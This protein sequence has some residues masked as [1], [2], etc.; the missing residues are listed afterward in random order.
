MK[1]RK[2]KNKRKKK[3]HWVVRL[4]EKGIGQTKYVTFDSGEGEG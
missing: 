3:K 4:K 2:R 1:K